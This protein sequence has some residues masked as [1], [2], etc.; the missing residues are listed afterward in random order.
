M[1]MQSS[2]ERNQSH[3]KTYQSSLELEKDKYQGKNAEKTNPLGSFW[4]DSAFRN[5]YSI[6]IHDLI[7]VF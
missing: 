5:I 7:T 3:G 4:M 1:V 6:Q 2:L